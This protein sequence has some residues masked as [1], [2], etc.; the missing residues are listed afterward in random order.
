MTNEQTTH[1]GD[2]SAAELE[3][4][5]EAQ[6]AKVDSDL[7]KLQD[8]FSPGQLMD[9][10]VDYVKDGDGAKF[11]RNLGR[12]VRDNP[13]PLMLIGA[14]IAWMM[15]SGGRSSSD[16]YDD[17]YR[18]NRGLSAGLLDAGGHPLETYGTS[19]TDDDGDSLKDKAG[20]VAADL[21]GRAQAVRGKIDDAMQ[22]AGETAEQY[23][24]RMRDR[25][26]AARGQV[27]DRLQ[28]AGETAQQYR[29][30]MRR[31][32]EFYGRR[33]KQGFFD[34]L[35]EQP[36]VLGAIG[37]AV[38]AALGA[39][40]PATEREDELMGERRDQLKD[41]AVQAGLQQAEKAQDK[42]EAVV[43]AAKDEISKGSSAPSETT[44]SSG[45]KTS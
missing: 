29:E 21:K 23:R 6:R 24:D 41:Q 25:A 40:L 20:Q 44:T 8:Q 30:R 10:L 2:K 11:T 9:Q 14:G 33:A 4:E 45:S 42:A 3:R 12:S 1:P 5:A 28:R 15:A 18:A 38:G 26:G 39:A 19:E 13:M 17:D 31:Q 22:R 7:K 16:R 36:L 35:E 37:V 32:A 34:T 27:D 43:Q